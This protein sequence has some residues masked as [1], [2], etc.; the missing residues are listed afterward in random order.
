MTTEQA[1]FILQ[2]CRPGG[3]DAADPAFVEA[4][5]QAERDP[6]LKAWLERERA[7]DAQVVSKCKMVVPPASLRV[8]ILAGG[9]A[10]R[11][12]QPQ[13][14]TLVGVGLAA[15]FALIFG[16]VAVSRLSGSDAYL[17]ELVQ[18]SLAEMSG[19][20][21]RG[22]PLDK[23][24]ELGVL[25]RDPAKRLGNNL[26]IDLDKLREIGCRSVQVA[27]KEVFEICFRRDSFYHLY[28]ARRAD[29]SCR[30]CEIEPMFRERGEFASVSWVDDDHVFVLV[31]RAGLDAVK[32]TVE[33]PAALAM[34]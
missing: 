1:K 11:R 29:F 30:E 28:I 20:H 19:P 7:F 6:A 25:L 27:G 4:L 5:A 8:A 22:Q 18:H 23:Y 16:T 21:P 10:S 15:C 31:S 32:R 17:D 34:R 14:R 13:W 12:S 9:R 24:G 33:D 2:A 26:P 3:Q